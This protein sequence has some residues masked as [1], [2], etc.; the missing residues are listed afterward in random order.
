[1]T[2]NLELQAKVPKIL[3]DDKVKLMKVFCVL[4]F[5]LI[6]FPSSLVS[7]LNWSVILK[8]LNTNAIN[9]NR[10]KVLLVE[11]LL[12]YLHADFGNHIM[13]LIIY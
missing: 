1:L 7:S 6:S 12:V 3:L 9:K 5:R 8:M 11:N 13:K 10:E 4:N 2:N